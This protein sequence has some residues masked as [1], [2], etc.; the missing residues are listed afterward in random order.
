VIVEI[1]APGAIEVEPREDIPDARIMPVSTRAKQRF[2]IQFNPSVIHPNDVVE[3][4]PTNAGTR[5]QPVPLAGADVVMQRCSVAGYFYQARPEILHV[6]V[7][8]FEIM[9]GLR[10]RPALRGE[11][12]RHP[13]VRERSREL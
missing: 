6:S 2:K 1:D 3:E 13:P 8:L 11:F 5:T 10:D 4:H 7:L 9:L 12:V